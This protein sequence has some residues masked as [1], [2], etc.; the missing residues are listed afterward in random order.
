LIFPLHELAQLQPPGTLFSAAWQAL[1]ALGFLQPPWF[2]T[3][4]SGLSL[5]GPRNTVA[6]R[7]CAQPGP[8]TDA[9]VPRA[10]SSPTN[11]T[12]LDTNRDIDALPRI[13]IPL[14]GDDD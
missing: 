7:C 5:I 6:A 8:L 2:C 13:E 12:I 3:G 11:R 14:P 9:N 1:K 4:M 10:A